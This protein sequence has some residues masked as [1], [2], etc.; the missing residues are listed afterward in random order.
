MCLQWY[1]GYFLCFENAKTV[2]IIQVRAIMWM[3]TQ[4]LFYKTLVKGLHHWQ[5]ERESNPATAAVVQDRFKNEHLGEHALRLC[6]GTV[7]QPLT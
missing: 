6:I 4:F 2:A 1:F 7:A 3:S 5:R